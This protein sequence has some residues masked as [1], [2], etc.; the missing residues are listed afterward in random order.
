MARALRILINLTILIPCYCTIQGCSSSAPA[1]LSG[2]YLAETDGSSIA[3]KASDWIR[4]NI[5]HPPNDPYLLKQD[6]S[7]VPSWVLDR[8][9]TDDWTFNLDTSLSTGSGLQGFYT[10]HGSSI[11]IDF[12]TASRPFKL[13]GREWRNLKGTVTPNGSE[14]QL[15]NG[16]HPLVLHRYHWNTQSSNGTVGVDLD[17]AKMNRD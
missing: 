6:L 4:K 5:P 17:P 11:E 12:T 15:G 1:H 13:L 2:E 16:P 7:K 8:E 3:A 9:L 14:I 10:I